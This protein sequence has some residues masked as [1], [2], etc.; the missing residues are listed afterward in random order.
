MAL[1]EADLLGLPDAGTLRLDNL[2][3]GLLAEMRQA[4]PLRPGRFATSYRIA[5]QLHGIMPFLRSVLHGQ[6]FLGLV[7]DFPGLA[8][9]LGRFCSIPDTRTILLSGQEPAAVPGFELC[10]QALAELT[11]PFPGAIFLVSVSGPFGP[12]FCGRIR[13]LGGIALDIGTIAGAWASR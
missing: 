13:Q 8:S 2:H 6:P 5:A 12:A 9:R 10:E 4:V 3:F 11:I 7:G 1:G